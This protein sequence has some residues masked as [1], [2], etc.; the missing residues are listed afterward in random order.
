MASVAEPVA[1]NGTGLIVPDAADSPASPSGFSSALTAWKG[2]RRGEGECTPK[3]IRRALCR[4][5]LDR[6]AEVSGCSRSRNCREPKGEHGRTEEA[7][8]T[9][10]RC[11]VLSEARRT[12]HLLCPHVTEFKK[13]SDD[14]KVEAF[15]GLLK[16]RSLPPARS[17]MHSPPP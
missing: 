11:E 9:D 1:L 5:Q 10:A 8:R 15:K 16:G 2:G 13:I 14:Q 7:G 3:L 17:H 12:S 6:L 4:H